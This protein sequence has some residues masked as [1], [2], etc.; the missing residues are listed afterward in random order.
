MTNQD[1]QY[2]IYIR[3]TKQW[4]P[5]TEEVY[6]EYYRPV[7]RTQKAAQKSG[8]CVC[9]K[10]KLWVCDGDCAVCGYHVAG[11]TISLDAQM[12]NAD[13]DEFSLKDTIEDPTSNFADV[14][15]DRLLLE[16]LLDELAEHD[17]EGKRIKIKYK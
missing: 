1:K 9:P 3:N 15:V 7:W 12:K 10:S 16:Q 8:Q 13:G 4:V 14:L 17:P 11:N 5:V 2:K 6:L